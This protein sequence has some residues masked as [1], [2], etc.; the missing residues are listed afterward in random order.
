MITERSFRRLPLRDLLT[1]AE[2]RIRDLVEHFNVT[3]LARVADLRD[4][5][6]PIRKRSH[7]P[8]LHA[9]QN[10]LQKA[11]DTNA[12]TRQ[13]IDY[14]LQELNEILEHA[15]REQLARR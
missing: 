4:L 7:Y 14:L 15:R 8:T 3:W 10:A 11:V 13:I 5:S 6:R 9:L 12:E 1:D 2:K